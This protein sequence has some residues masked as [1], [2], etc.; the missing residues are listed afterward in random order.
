[1]QK[2]QSQE[3]YIHVVCWA[4]ERY[5]KGGEI[6]L[7]ENGERSAYSKIEDFAFQRYIMRKPVIKFR[8]LN[9][10]RHIREKHAG[11]AKMIH[12]MFPEYREKP[13][14]HEHISYSGRRPMTGAIV[15]HM[16]GTYF[17]NESGEVIQKHS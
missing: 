3:K 5:S 17:D 4:K 6:P 15:C 10:F 8:P 9:L 14:Q 1:M 2:K 11:C 12:A 7:I 16:C 13:C